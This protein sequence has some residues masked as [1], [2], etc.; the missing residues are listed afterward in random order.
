MQT[1]TYLSNYSIHLL[2]VVVFQNV[3]QAKWLSDFN[4]A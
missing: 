1:G 2:Q 4:N 3:R